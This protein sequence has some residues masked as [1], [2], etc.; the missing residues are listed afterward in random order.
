MS[1]FQTFGL[2]LSA[3]LHCKCDKG[4]GTERRG[5]TFSC[6]WGGSIAMGISIGL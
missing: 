4:E 1:N 5:S 6:G 2:E 3:H